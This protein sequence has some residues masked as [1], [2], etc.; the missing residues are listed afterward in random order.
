MAPKASIFNRKIHRW[1]AIGF[2]APILII[3]VSGI[4]LQL[5][6]HVDWIQPPSRRGA[7]T[8]PRVGFDAILE[9]AR[10][11]PAARIEGWEDIDRLDVRPGRG[12]VKV[13]AKTGWEVQI[14]T[15]NG[16]VLQAAYRRS[17]VIE[18]IHD[19]SF[20]HDKV[21]MGLFM[22]SGIVLLLLWITGI[23]LFVLPHQAKR[24]A[25]KRSGA[26]KPGSVADPGPR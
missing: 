18:D 15:E 19:G 13:Q 17:D 9:A 7:G 21:K 5:K 10:T 14:D 12:I 22:T 23:Y 1:V 4:L 11:V 25:R 6:K 26:G 2:S 3:L 8:V 20:F 24:R 16:E